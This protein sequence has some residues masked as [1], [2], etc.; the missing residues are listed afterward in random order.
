MTYL[1]TVSGIAFYEHPD[2]D[3][4]PLCFKSNGKFYVSGFY[5]K[6]D[7]QE[8]LDMSKVEFTQV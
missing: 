1:F 3:D 2:G 4:M 8:V 5:D 7:T 6:P